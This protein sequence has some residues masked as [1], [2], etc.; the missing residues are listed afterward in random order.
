MKTY[1]YKDNNGNYVK[2][3]FPKPTEKE[4]MMAEGIIGL[5]CLLIF[6]GGFIYVVVSK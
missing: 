5:I 6:I 3:I 4:E 2:S 1:R